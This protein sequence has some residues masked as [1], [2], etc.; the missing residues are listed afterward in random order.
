MTDP[1]TGQGLQDRS[2]IML[3]DGSA[4]YIPILEVD[5]L[6]IGG[7]R[8]YAKQGTRYANGRLAIEGRDDNS[9][10]I[11]LNPGK[12]CKGKGVISQVIWYAQHFVDSFKRF[13]ISI[14]HDGD[15]ERVVLDSTSHESVP[16]MPMYITSGAKSRSD[17]TDVPNSEKIA[18]SFF[19][20]G[21]HE[22]HLH[23]DTMRVEMNSFIEAFIA[24]DK[25]KLRA[26]Q[27]VNG[28]WQQIRF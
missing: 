10:E 3:P 27:L 25:S 6:V 28:S 26:R 22:F 21:T 15:N 16:A 14:V 17:G 5:R 23:N 12:N 7:H 2:R 24:N 9:L 11:E 13:A 8:I 4:N 18:F 19:H 20:N 1:F